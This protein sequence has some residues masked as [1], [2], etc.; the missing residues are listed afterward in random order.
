MI[1]DSVRIFLVFIIK[2]KTYFVLG[3]GGGGHFNSFGE[4]CQFNSLGGDG[5]HCNSLGR[6]EGDGGYFSFF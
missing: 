3:G 6:G 2:K 4:G 1:S 5:G